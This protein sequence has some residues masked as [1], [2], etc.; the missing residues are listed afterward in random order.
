MK[1][2]MRQVSAAQRLQPG[3][4]RHLWRKHRQR[5]TERRGKWFYQASCQ[6]NLD[7]NVSSDPAAKKKP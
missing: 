4:R 1:R 3:K 7:A 2:S 5:L 6:E